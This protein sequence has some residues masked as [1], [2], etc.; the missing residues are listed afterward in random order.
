MLDKQNSLIVIF[1]VGD[2]RLG[3]NIEQV[4]EI[5]SSDCTPRIPEKKDTAPQTMTFHGNSIPVISW[6]EKIGLGPAASDVKSRILVLE[7]GC[8]YLGVLVDSVDLIRYMDSNALESFSP[9]GKEDGRKSRSFDNRDLP[10]QLVTLRD[11][12][13]RD[14]EVLPN[15]FSSVKP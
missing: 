13:K 1:S 7:D 3:I 11:V 4:A 14:F 15:I 5:I 9:A 12:E 8:Q 2:L 10:D 6:R